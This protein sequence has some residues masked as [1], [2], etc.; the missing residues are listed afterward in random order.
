MKKLIILCMA[1]LLAGSVCAQQTTK[2]II[3]ERQELAKASKKELNEKSSKAARKEARKLEKEGWKV[4]PG[5]LPLE[6]QLDRA[7]M[8][9]LEYD[10]N[11][12]PR[13]IISN[14]MSVGE[15]YDAAKMQA[16]ELAKLELAAQIQ[17]EVT[18]L[19]DNSIS[20][21]QLAGEEAASITKSISESKSIISQNIGRVI[22]VTEAY[23]EN[24]KNKNKEVLIRI[25]YSGE[26]AKAAAKAAIH[27]ELEK[28]SDELRKKLDT[29]IGW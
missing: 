14:A 20:N 5:A 22:T 27:A 8:M 26:M 7:Y 17:T 3:K 18:A 9:Q 28:C 25:A 23:K 29:I 21:Q 19:I 10:A 24:K 12:Y 16:L 13:Y 15:N 6:K 2:E 4:A 1:C 11:Y